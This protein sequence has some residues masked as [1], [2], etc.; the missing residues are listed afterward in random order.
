MPVVTKT[1]NWNSGQ[2]SWVIGTNVGDTPVYDGGFGWFDCLDGP[3]FGG[4][5][6]TFT[7][8]GATAGIYYTGT[9]EDIGVPP[10]S[11]VT[12]ILSSHG[13]TNTQFQVFSQVNPAPEGFVTLNN[14]LIRD[15]NQ[16]IIHTLISSRTLPD[17]GTSI[18]AVSGDSSTLSIASSQQARIQLGWWADTVLND[19]P[20]GA[21]F[22]R[23]IWDSF[24]LNVEYKTRYSV[25]NDQSNLVRGV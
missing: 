2:D 14:C 7:T 19:F 12:K 21:Y 10:G 18:Q 20:V 11:T 25:F 4:V 3:N 16:N 24:T 23:L 17:T 1:W 13:G 15:A 22:T 6:R 8:T 5:N 9:W